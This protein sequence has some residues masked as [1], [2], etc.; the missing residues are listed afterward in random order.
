MCVV[1]VCGFVLVSLELK[2]VQLTSSLT[3]AVLAVVKEVLLVLL[4][5][6]VMGEELTVR[7]VCGF[8]I[9]LLGVGLYKT[10]QQQHQQ[11]QQERKMALA[12]DSHCVG[13][14]ACRAA[15]R[16][17]LE[18]F[19]EAI[20]D[21]DAALKLESTQHITHYRKGYVEEHPQ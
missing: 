2:L 20:A 12:V 18:K 7:C 19:E 14:Y 13:A 5:V 8:A 16:L 21:A 4:S 9:T 3:F 15:A 11:Q 6:S 10:Q 17:R 1:S